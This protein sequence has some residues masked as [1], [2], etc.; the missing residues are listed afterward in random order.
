MPLYDLICPACG[1]SHPGVYAKMGE[2]DLYRC[3][4]CGTHLTIDWARQGPPRTP[5]LNEWTVRQGTSRAHGCAPSEV[6][7]MRRRI[8]QRGVGGVTVSDQGDI[9]FLNRKAERDFCKKVAQS[10]GSD[11]KRDDETD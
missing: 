10:D 11:G 4:H 8:D 7:Q 9:I 3:A 6:R 5:D 2:A 1:R